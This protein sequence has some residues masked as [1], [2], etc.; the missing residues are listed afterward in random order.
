AEPGPDADTMSALTRRVIV[1]LAAAGECVIVGRGGNY[2]LRERSDAFHLFVY[3][4]PGWRVRRLESE[5]QSRADAQG[6]V[7]RMDH[8]RAAYIRRYFS[9]EWGERHHYH[10]QI[11]A[12]L[13]PAA[14]I[15]ATL[16]ALAK[17]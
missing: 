4:A 1:D 8:D 7:A 14:V 3:A 5:G 13:G 16:A 17:S 6:L 12:A 2:V 9:Q 15:A 11:N 10:L